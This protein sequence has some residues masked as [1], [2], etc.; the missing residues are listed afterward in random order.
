MP[1]QPQW[2]NDPHGYFANKVS[3]F[4][5][6]C[7]LVVE[8]L[9]D[10]GWDWAVWASDRLEVCLHGTADGPEEAKQAAE[11]AA[12]LLDHPQRVYLLRDT[13]ALHRPQRVLS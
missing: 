3:M 10:R 6:R 12:L 11:R 5:G 13:R 8:R 9:P 1:R 4:H 2:S 7:H